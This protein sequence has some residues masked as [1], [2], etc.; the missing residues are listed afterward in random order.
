MFVIGHR[1]ARALEPE[2]TLRSLRRG[3]E[4]ATF[5]EVDVRLSRDGHVVVMHDATV[6]RTTNGTGEVGSLTF[7]ELK[8]LDAGG[9]EHIPAFSEVLDLVV[10]RNGGLVVEIKEPGSEEAICDLLAGNRPE[11]LFVV[12]F[13]P[14]TI[15]R[16]RELLS[17]VATGLIYSRIQNDPLQIAV[18]VN[19]TVILPKFTRVTPA[20]VGAA[21]AAGLPVVAWTLNTEE[22]FARAVSLGIDGFASDNPCMARDFL[23]AHGG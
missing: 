21:H 7:A 19:A 14:E 20:L 11:P 23:A 13:H 17:D 6:D 2:N 9:G 10:G 15:R 1:G 22:E 16:A 12:S 8:R 3:M 5:V 4:C 18:S